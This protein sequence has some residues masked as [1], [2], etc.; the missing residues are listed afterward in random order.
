MTTSTV[1]T[2][3]V[4]RLL[5]APLLVIAAAILIK[6]YADVGDGF[7]AGVIAA[8]G[9]ALQLFAFGRDEA[10]GLM[11]RRRAYASAVT[12]LALALVVA[13]V[14]LLRGDPVLTHLP[15]AQTEVTKL[16]S[17]ELITAFAFD[18]A[19]ALL[20]FGVVAGVLDALAEAAEREPA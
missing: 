4:A 14:P 3:T 10:G 7:S 11:P 20:V 18:V 1:L 15:G 19:L 9:F 12:G 16:G 6:G 13:F 8:L 2:Q 17:L 5:L